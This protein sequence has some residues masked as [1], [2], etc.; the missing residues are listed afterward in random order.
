VQDRERKQSLAEAEATYKAMIDIYSSMGHDLIHLPLASVDE[1]T[2]FVMNA[3][4]V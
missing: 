1:R 4:G 3:M 2:Q